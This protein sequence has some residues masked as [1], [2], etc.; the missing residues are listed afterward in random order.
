MPE[1][2]RMAKATVPPMAPLDRRSSGSTAWSADQVRARTPSD[3]DSTSVATPRARGTLAHLRAQA[4][5]SL[6]SVRISP[7]GA[8]TDT[9]QVVAPRII[10]PS[11]TACPP[12]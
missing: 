8:R 6:T 11:M 4:G 10:T 1:K 3:I 9:A 5:A 7:S 2:N 12:T